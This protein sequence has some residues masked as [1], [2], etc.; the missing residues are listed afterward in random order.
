MN[1]AEQE[2]LG[3][4]L[5][6]LIDI[7]ITEKDASAEAM[8]LEAV[9]RQP[10]AAYLLVQR[11]LLQNQA[12]QTAQTQ[13]VDLQNQLKQKD[14]NTSNNRFLNNDPWSPTTNNSPGVPGASAYKMPAANSNPANPDYVRPLQQNPTAGLGSSFLGNIATTAAGVVAG[15]FL[16]Q[17]IGNLLGHHHAAPE[18]AHQS[19]DEHSPEQTAT[20]H[21]QDDNEADNHFHSVNDDDS[22]SIFDDSDS[23][24][25][26]I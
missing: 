25:D 23:D 24:S 10:D 6:Q 12:L 7:K 1:T 22:D 17:G 15:S 5:T 26:W 18:I 2:Q 8:I 14:S 13:I 9:A 4:L 11:C 21:Q 3:Q 20:H 19:S 16:F